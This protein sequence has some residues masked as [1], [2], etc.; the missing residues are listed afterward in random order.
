[1]SLEVHVRRAFGPQ[2]T[3]DVQFECASC[4][5]ANVFG[6]KHTVAR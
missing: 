3:L 4:A 1:M 2:F 6:P 5:L